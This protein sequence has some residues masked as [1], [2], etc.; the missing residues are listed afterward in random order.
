MDNL[1]VRDNDISVRDGGSWRFGVHIAATAPHSIGHVSVTG[2]TIRKAE[3]GIVFEGP[4]FQQ[5]PMCSLNRTGEDVPVPF[6]GIQNLP[7]E[8]MVVGGATNRGGTTA[9]SGTGS[10]LAGLGDP[11]NR[12]MG[13]VG[14]IFQRL[15]GMPGK[16]FYVKESGHNTVSGWVAK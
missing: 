1:S 4:G 3:K 15:D 10:F 6:A 8:S 11:D 13:N 12:V 2:N 14:D 9:N 7:C 16:T 5:M